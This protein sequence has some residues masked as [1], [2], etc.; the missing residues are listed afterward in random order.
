MA[1]IVVKLKVLL[2]L[3]FRGAAL[4]IVAENLAL[5]H[6]TKQSHIANK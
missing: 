5:K 4:E 3:V 2:N 1:G 6:R